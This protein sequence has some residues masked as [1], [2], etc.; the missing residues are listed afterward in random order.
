MSTCP[1]CS[2][3]GSICTCTRRSR[4]PPR[5][6]CCSSP[7]LS[8]LMWIHVS[9]SYKNRTEQSPPRAT[10]HAKDLPAR[11]HLERKERW[12]SCRGEISGC[13]SPL[14]VWERDAQTPVRARSREGR[15]EIPTKRLCTG[16]DGRSLP[17]NC[18]ENTDLGFYSREKLL[19]VLPIL[20]LH[21]AFCSEKNCGRVL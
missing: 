6:G 5:R 10:R 1:G 19:L 11:L 12:L 15:G 9:D 2:R 17:A 8:L 3:P 7:R 13:G 20:P 4:S 21:S 18:V 14:W 16:R